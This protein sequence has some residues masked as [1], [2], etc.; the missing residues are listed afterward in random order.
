MTERWHRVEELYHAALERLPEDRLGFLRD[1]CGDEDSLYREV[2]SLLAQE[3]ADSGFLE[4]WAAHAAVS[5]LDSTPSGSPTVTTEDDQL[6][7]FPRSDR[8]AMLRQFRTGGMGVVYEALDR[9]RNVRVALKVLPRVEPR[10]LLRF[11]EEFRTIGSLIHPNLVSLYE[12][13]SDGTLWY[14]TMELVEG[15]DFAAY[16]GSPPT[17]GTPVDDTVVGRGVC[18]GPSAS[19]L[20]HAQVW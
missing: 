18:P 11:K 3:S 12:L 7:A 15:I 19:D 1:A 16:I 6:S 17:L 13:F 9:E 5:V 8:F 14:F 10:G 2:E 20:F 4:G